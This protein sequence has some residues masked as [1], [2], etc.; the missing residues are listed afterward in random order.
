M[1]RGHAYS[2]L[3]IACALILASGCVAGDGGQAKVKSGDTVL[4]HYTGTLENG[5]VFDSSTGREPLGFVVGN[6][7]VI[8]GFEAGVVGMQAGETKTIHIP[9]DQA[10]GPYRAEL[11]FAVDPA[12]ITGGENLIVGESVELTLPSGQVL[13]ARVAG[14]SPGAVTI[15]ANHRLA[16]VDLTFNVTLVEIG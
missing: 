12:S 16:G 11:V 14:V 6:G 15:D 9:A 2:V 13:P 8:P 3:L 7:E 10:Y 4:V 1:R 5:T